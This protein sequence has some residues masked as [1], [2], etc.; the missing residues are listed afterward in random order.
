M[1]TIA[2]TAQDQDERE[3]IVFIHNIGKGAWGN[4]P[5]P[6]TPESITMDGTNGQLN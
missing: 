5:R 4:A 2:Y 3:Y 6:D 1:Y